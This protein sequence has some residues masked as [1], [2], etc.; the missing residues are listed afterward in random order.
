MHLFMA[1]LREKFLAEIDSYLASSGMNASEF[2]T[3]VMSD[4]TFVYRI[5]RG[6]EP[7][8]DTI[9]KVSAWIASH[10]PTPRKR[11]GNGPEHVAA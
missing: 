8:S 6:R 11:R 9:D 7:R 3:S 10:P 1:T 4:P 2:G 5:R